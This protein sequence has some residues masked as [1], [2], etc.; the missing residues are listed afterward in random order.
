M[1]YAGFWIR[2]IPFLI[3]QIIVNLPELLLEQVMV[4]FTGMDS[5]TQQLWGGVLS[6]IFYYWYYCRYQVKKGTTL[7][8][9]LFHLQVVDE[10]TGKSLNHR[11]AV[12][13]SFGYLVSVVIVGCGF[14]MAAF[15]PR[16]K[17]LHDGFAGTVCVRVPKKPA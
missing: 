3:D 8:K 11:Q 15:H 10:R 5:F 2:A 7:G 1:N 16:K 9:K 6:L 4:H 17:T 13:R 12:I 14:L